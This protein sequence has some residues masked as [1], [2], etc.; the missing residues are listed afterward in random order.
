MQEIANDPP[1]S[2]CLETAG[3]LT[4]P[5]KIVDFLVAPCHAKHELSYANT[6]RSYKQLRGHLKN[7]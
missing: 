6:W 4:L 7:D 1:T 2:E 5:P 3:E